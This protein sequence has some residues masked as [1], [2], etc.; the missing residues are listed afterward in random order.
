MYSITINYKEHTQR[1]IR[2]NLATYKDVLTF[3]SNPDNLWSLDSTEDFDNFRVDYEDVYAYYR[4][5]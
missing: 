2:G 1:V 5:A 4:Q 3:L